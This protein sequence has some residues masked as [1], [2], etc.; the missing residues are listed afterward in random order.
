MPLPPGADAPAF[1]LPSSADG[2]RSLTDIAGDG[3]AL[4]AFLK[5]GC[6]TCQLAFPLYAELERRYGDAV[7]V[8]AVTQDSLDQTVPWLEDK[9]FAGMVLDD[10]SDRYA[11]SRSYGVST[12]PTLVMVD[13]GRIVESIQAWDRDQVNAWARRLG[14]RTGRDT[15]PVSTEGDGRPAFK[16]G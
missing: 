4:L 12:V 11:V 2:R 5:I 15:S 16:P 13:G 6:P 9:G 3:P 10:A 8:V 14:E 7:P 1:D